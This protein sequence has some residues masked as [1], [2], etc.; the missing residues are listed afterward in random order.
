MSDCYDKHSENTNHTEN[1]DYFNFL[2]EYSNSEPSQNT[3]LIEKYNKNTKTTLKK[4]NVQKINCE[5]I[6]D[7]SKNDVLYYTERKLLISKSDFL[8]GKVGNK[9]ELLK[10]LQNAINYMDDLGGYYSFKEDG[11][12]Y[13]N[14]P[15]IKGE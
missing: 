10:L 12:F 5:K 8:S 2:D 9:K 15:V 6:Q 4:D 7:L 11:E 3:E 14:F 1:D 13:L